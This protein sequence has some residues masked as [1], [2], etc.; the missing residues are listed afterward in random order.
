MALRHFSDGDA[1]VEGFAVEVAGA[2]FADVDAQ[3]Y[4]GPVIPSL[5]LSTQSMARSA[6]ASTVFVSPLT[7]KV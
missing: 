1:R 6:A 7:V 5:S 2:G 4:I 3:P